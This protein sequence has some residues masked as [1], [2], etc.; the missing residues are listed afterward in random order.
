MDRDNSREEKIIENICDALNNMSD[1]EKGYM[2]GV[3]ET[4]AAD[5]EKDGV[6][7]D[8]GDDKKPL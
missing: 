3:I 4:R 7:T 8:K 5:K 1:F 6:K 2:L